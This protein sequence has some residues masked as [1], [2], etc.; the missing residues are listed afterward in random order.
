MYI[1][2]CY[3]YVLYI[4]TFNFGKRGS[5][6]YQTFPQFVSDCCEWVGGSSSL[7]L[8]LR[9]LDTDFC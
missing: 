2:L 3:I 7:M 5:L 6:R 9:T 4:N 1:Y 8:R